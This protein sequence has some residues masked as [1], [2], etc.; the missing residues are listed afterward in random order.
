MATVGISK[1]L[2][3][4]VETKINGMR[5]AERS[6]DLPDIDKNYSIDAS[7]LYNIGCWGV[8]HVHLLESIPKDWLTKSGDASITIH[9]WTDEAVQLK[10][11]VRFTGMT[12]AYQRP[13]DN[14]YNRADSELTLDQ[15]RAFPEETPGRAELLQRWDDA[16][17]EKAIDARWNKVKTDITEFLGKCKSLNEA[18]KLFP[19]VRMYIHYE[20]LERLDRKAERPTQRAKIVEEVDTEGL[21]A[22]AIAAKLAMAA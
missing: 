20:D 21:T 4:R 5:K 2:I 10:T 22:A 7:K 14:Y 12:F 18:V 8:D 15:V 1:E 6:S 13:R 9:G 16:V 17:I 3:N 19:G 11:S